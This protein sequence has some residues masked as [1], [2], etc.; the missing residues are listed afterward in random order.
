MSDNAGTNSNHNTSSLPPPSA[1]ESILLGGLVVGVLD[2]LAGRPYRGSSLVDQRL[3]SALSGHFSLPNWASSPNKFE[4]C[5]FFFRS[6]CTLTE[7]FV[8]LGITLVLTTRKSSRLPS[9][10]SL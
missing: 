4:F 1:L 7:S 2:I 8:S 10:D 3:K 5:K 6:F 9:S